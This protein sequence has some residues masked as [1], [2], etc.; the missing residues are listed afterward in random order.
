MFPT[1][2]YPSPTHLQ[3]PPGE[4]AFGRSVEV[5]EIF[6]GDDPLGG[7]EMLQLQQRRPAVVKVELQDGN[8]AMK[9]RLHGNWDR[10]INVG[11]KARGVR[12]GK[13]KEGEKRG[14]RREIGERLARGPNM[15]N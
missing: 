9:A 15:K 1:S 11:F 12:K 2:R 6:V 3:V 7:L 14:L 4:S 8:G 5:G 10:E 13:F